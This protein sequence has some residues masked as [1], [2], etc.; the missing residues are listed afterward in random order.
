MTILAAVVVGASLALAG[1]I[2]QSLFRNPLA[3]PYMLGMVGGGALFAALAVVC[4]L[5]AAGAFVLPCVSFLGSLLSLSLVLWVA[6]CAARQRSQVGADAALRASSSTIVL[7]GFVVGSLMGSLDMLVLSYANP[8]DF[9]RLSK[10]L[11]GSLAAITPFSLTLGCVALAVVIGVLMWYSKELTIMELGRDEAECL[12]VN[13]RQVM[14]VVI[15]TVALATSISVAL[16]GAVGFVG[17]VVPH[18]AR[19]LV[20]G[21]MQRLLPLSAFLGA[22]F[23]AGAQSLTAV[24]PHMSIG[25]ICAIVGAPFFLFL[26]S[27]YGKGEGRDV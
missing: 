4:G 16:A 25:V 9:T 8:E 14:M 19:R 7:A 15:G 20:G 22:G 27:T 13:T 2:L 24:F 11:Y 10:W 12:G 18:G 17:L 5:T 21:K 23:L 3:E 6:H 1:A 26:L